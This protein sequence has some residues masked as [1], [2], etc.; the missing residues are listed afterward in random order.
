MEK[1]LRLK[2]AAAAIAALDPAST[3]I[4]PAATSVI[5][6][7]TVPDARSRGRYVG[8]FGIIDSAKETVLLKLPDSARFELDF[9]GYTTVSGTS[10]HCVTASGADLKAWYRRVDCAK[11]SVQMLGGWLERTGTPYL[12]SVDFPGAL[13]GALKQCC[14]E[15]YEHYRTAEFENNLREADE[16]G[17]VFDD[18]HG[19]IDITVSDDDDSDYDDSDASQM[20]HFS[21][22]A[23]PAASEE[24]E[25][26]QQQQET[27]KK[28]AALAVAELL[29]KTI[30]HHVF[31]D[32]EDV[33]RGD[34][35]DCQP[36]KRKMPS[37]DDL[38]TATQ[39]KQED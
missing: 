2:P 24:V 3:Q 33:T 18:G 16:R 31:Q 28:R 34:D 32:E 35:D 19:G 21:L 38:D 14:E 10:A 23:S 5:G 6:S 12:G 15:V 9:R 25:P 8:W 22:P 30:V 39:E 27:R 37:D 29:R 36:T 26:H 7:F 11:A 13:C 4:V 20:S 17:E 1:L